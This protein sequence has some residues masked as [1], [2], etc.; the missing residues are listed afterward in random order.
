VLLRKAVFVSLE[1]NTM[2]RKESGMICDEV[3]DYD[4]GSTSR[5]TD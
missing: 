1:E 3:W 2:L 4:P 5:E